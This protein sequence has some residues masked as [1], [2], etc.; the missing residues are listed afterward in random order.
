MAIRTTTVYLGY[1]P[2]WY[3][4]E[5]YIQGINMPE[6]PADPISIN[7]S[8]I[9][10]EIDQNGLATTTFLTKNGFRKFS[11]LPDDIP[12]Y[13]VLSIENIRSYQARIF[14][15]TKQMS[16]SDQQIFI[17]G[18]RNRHRFQ[19]L[20]ELYEYSC[21]NYKHVPTIDGRAK[22]IISAMKICSPDLLSDWTIKHYIQLAFVHLF[23]IF[24]GGKNVMVFKDQ[25]VDPL[26]ICLY[27]QQIWWIMHLS[28]NIFDK[29]YQ[30][31][32]GNLRLSPIMAC[33]IGSTDFA[34]DFVHI[35]IDALV[36]LFNKFDEKLMK[37]IS[38]LGESHEIIIQKLNVSENAALLIKS[39]GITMG[40]INR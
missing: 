34:W 10:L 39:W 24:A 40:F 13:Y 4:P 3:R 31:L 36:F 28:C 22:S 27:G 7:E 1:E 38:N 29:F 37:S 18:F 19:T 12:N 14:S 25:W 15:I 11:I 8:E 21:A 9:E 16:S 30:K 17:S 20:T 33:E 23:Y 32:C 2:T 26:T 5:E 6:K 35:W